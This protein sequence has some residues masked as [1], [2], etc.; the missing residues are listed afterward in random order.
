[1]GGGCGDDEGH[2]KYIH[3]YNEGS[4]PVKKFENKPA[5][6]SVNRQLLRNAATCGDT[7]GDISLSHTFLSIYIYILACRVSSHHTIWPDCGLIVV[8]VR[9][10]NRSSCFL[11]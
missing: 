5:V 1:M 7:A 2:D 3:G 8:C 10:H 9:D 6:I 11:Q 4:L